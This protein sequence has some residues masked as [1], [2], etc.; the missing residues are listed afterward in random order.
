MTGTEDDQSDIGKKEIVME[1]N[2]YG[3]TNLRVRY[4]NETGCC[5]QEEDGDNKTNQDPDPTMFFCKFPNYIDNC[6]MNASI[7]SILHL[8]IAR[9]FVAQHPK[10]IF[11]AMSET[12]FLADLLSSAMHHPGKDFSTQQIYQVFME[13]T[14]IVP[15]LDFIDENDPVYLLDAIL[16]WLNPGIKTGFKLYTASSCET[17]QTAY[18]NICEKGTIFQ[19]ERPKPFDTTTSL[20]NRMVAK[21]KKDYCCTCR[22]VYK[23][24]LFI[25]DN[26]VM[27]LYLDLSIRQE[28][29]RC[30]LIP[31]ATI[32]IPVKGGTQLY[33]LSS[34]I[35]SER[36]DTDLPETDHFY[37]YLMCGQ[38]V[39]KAEDTEFT[40]TCLSELTVRVT[41]HRLFISPE[42]GIMKSK[43][44]FV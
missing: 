18:F 26:D 14:E 39:Y 36:P 15:S 6:W 28:G 40:L 30:P 42:Q 23:K 43:G 7:Q 3:D 21:Y 27:V 29:L 5:Y 17:C 13:V 1:I 31:S 2:K 44:S 33:R 38:M 24:R 32:D 10:E 8:T 22:S 16:L 37:T 34:V 9:K 12:P 41:F 35:C 11:R 20:L 4:L 25:N 19:L